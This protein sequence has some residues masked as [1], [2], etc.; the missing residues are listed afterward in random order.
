MADVRAAHA[1]NDP[2]FPL[3]SALLCLPGSQS[4]DRARGH[5]L[6]TRRSPADSA[7]SGGH[8]TWVFCRGSKVR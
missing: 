7:R 6:G 2:G 1:A 3:T 5:N 8:N 4:S